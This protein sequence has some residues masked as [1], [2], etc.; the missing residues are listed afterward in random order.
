M[1]ELIV[2]PATVHGR[3]LVEA[4]RGARG[5]GGA[6]LLVGFHGYAENAERH[7]AELTAIPGVEGWVVAAAQGLHPFYNTKSGEVVASWMTKQD[8]E[9]AIADNVAYV[10]ALVERVRADTG[11]GGP[12]VYLGFSQGVAMAYR[13]AALAGHTAAGVIAIGGDLPP[14]LGEVGFGTLATGTQLRALVSRGAD[15]AWYTTE[16]MTA[17]LAALARHGVMFES[18]VYAGGHEWTAE[19]R[20]LAGRFLSEISGAASILA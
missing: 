19:L 16:K 20:A 2:L 1:P 9:L 18:A 10:G 5:A 14:E 15:D 3:V 6:P 7:L 8:R 12:L 17:D 13:A 11:A 4:P